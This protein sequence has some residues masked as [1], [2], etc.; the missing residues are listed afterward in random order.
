M[1]EKGE[2]DEDDAEVF[3]MVASAVEIEGTDPETVEEARVRPDWSKW[4]EAMQEELKALEDA[5]TWSIVEKPQG[6]NVVGCKWVFRIKRNADGEIDKYKARLVAKGYSQVYGIDYYDTYAP[7]A[8]LASLRTILAVAARNDWDVDVFDFQSAFLN[9]KLDED[10]V[11]YM[12]LPQ[13]LHHT[14]SS[15]KHPVARLHVALY[16][17]KQGALK[18]YNELCK[19]L[20]E[21]GLQ[22]SEADWGVFFMHDRSDILLLA[23]HVDDCTVTGN[24]SDRV[25]NFKTA[26]AAK[27][28][29]SDLGPIASLLGMKVT[30]NRLARTI[31]LSQEKYVEGILAKYNFTDLRPAA[32]PME[33]TA[34]LSASQSPKTLAEASR[35]KHVPYREAVG[36]LMH[37]AV[38]TRP[39]VAFAVAAVAQFSANPGIAHWEA[40]KRIFRYLA[41]TKDL[42]LTYGGT[43]D[44]LRGYTDAD[45]ASQ[46]HRHAIS[47]YAFILDGGAVSWASKKQELVTLSMTE[48]EYVAATHAAKEAI[49]LRRFL[50]ET[51]RPLIFPTMLH[52]DNQSAIALAKDGAYH[53]RTKH[54]DIRY[55]FIRFAIDEGAISLVYCPTGNMVA[56]TLTKPLPSLKV[57]HFAAALGLQRV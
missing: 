55:H 14:S 56:D 44:G 11:I 13:G 22:R 27:Y 37:V 7:V 12:Q 28:K 36:S 26:I 18:W 5:Q 50:Q 48:A 45:G 1:G 40:V 57:K 46:E 54:I 30:R 47:G 8:R 33:T 35:M 31:S 10:E 41:G 49:W 42:A 15:I 51:F 9:G 32:T 6:V 4:D 24:N 21:L 19:A 43:T 3:A 34:H 23:A 20:Y 38:G 53:A 2:V 52:C 25:R 16:G 17:S 29:L 39:D